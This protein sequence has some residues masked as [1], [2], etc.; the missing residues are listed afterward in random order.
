MSFQI[1]VKM[2]YSQLNSYWYPK[3]AQGNSNTTQV[4]EKCDKGDVGMQ[5]DS[6]LKQ[7][8]FKFHTLTILIKHAPV[9][10]LLF[11]LQA[12]ELALASED[13]HRNLQLNFIIC[14]GNSFF[15]TTF[16]FVDSQN[17]SCMYSAKSLNYT[18]NLKWP[19]VGSAPQVT[20]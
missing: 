14:P 10:T 15:K 9:S 17:S 1:A 4:E 13:S 12:L 11:L 8:L 5:R 2:L 3:K 16:R 19:L 20:R 6:G 18:F 7:V